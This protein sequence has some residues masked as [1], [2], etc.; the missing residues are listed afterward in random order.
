MMELKYLQQIDA[1]LT[2]KP[3]PEDIE[4]QCDAIA[5]KAMEPERTFIAMRL[6]SAFHPDEQANS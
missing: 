5:G 6:E 1:L 4:A 2:H 3:W